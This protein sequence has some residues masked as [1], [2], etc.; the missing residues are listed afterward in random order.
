MS[1]WWVFREV[2][3]RCQLGL[4]PS[5]DSTGMGVQVTHPP[6]WLLMLAASWVL[7]RAAESSSFM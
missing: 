4:E 2:I 5:A 3:G 7:S 1:T 6:G